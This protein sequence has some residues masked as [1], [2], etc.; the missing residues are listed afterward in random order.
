VV[1][2]WFRRKGRPRAA[3]GP[4][5]SSSAP[6]V[7]HWAPYLTI[8]QQRRVELLV[9]QWFAARGTSAELGVGFARVDGREYGL[10]N[11][12]QRCRPLPFD[13]WPLC[14]AQHFE[15][16]FAADAEQEEWTARSGDWDFVAPL[17]R[18]RCYPTD[19]LANGREEW[20]LHRPGLDETC[21]MVVADLPR[22]VMTVERALPEA[23]GKSVDD[24]F[25]FAMQ[26][27]LRECPITWEP[28][29]LD[30]S[31]TVLHV[32]SADHFFVTTHAFALADAP[33]LLGSDGAL[34]AVPDRQTMLVLPLVPGLSLEV[35]EKMA[36]IAA[37]RHEQGPGSVSPHLYW[38]RSD[39]TFAVQ[40]T[41]GKGASGRDAA[42]AEFI[43]LLQRLSVSPRAP[44][45]EE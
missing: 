4:S 29:A 18:V 35:V 28:F 15:G 31:G 24:V 36:G 40:R 5:P 43:A 23:W 10:E 6:A 17:L 45:D 30:A 20:V 19:Y 2:G 8:E 1:F 21:L 41:V 3:K 22:T 39:G 9:A 25:S 16:I 26:Q 38:R 12:A 34:V 27:T 13:E 42:S 37:R 44:R 11:V 14:V 33:H 7:P 32:A